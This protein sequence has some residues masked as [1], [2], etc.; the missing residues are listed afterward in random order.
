M[1]KHQLSHRAIFLLTAL[2]LALP[3]IALSPTVTP[4]YSQTT[5]TVSINPT[6]GP[7]GSPVVGTGSNWTAGDSMQ[8]SW[9]DTG[10]V[11][12]NT[13]TV[14]S[15]GRFSISFTIPVNATTG[16]HDIYFT[17]STSRY[18]LVATFTVAASQSPA[19]SWTSP[20]GNSGTFNV[21]SGSVTLQAS[22]SDNVGVARVKFTRWDAVAGKWVDLATV[23]SAPWQTTLAV[24]TLNS[25][26]NQVNVQA[27]DAAGNAST[28][29]YIWLNRTVAPFDAFLA[30]NNGKFLDFDGAYGAQC[31]DLVQYWSQAIGGPRFT[32]NYAKD[33]YKQTANFYTWIDKIGAAVPQKG[34]I[35]VWSGT[36]N[37]GP[38][39]VGIATGNG[40]KTF[41]EVFEQN[42]PTGS[43]SHL[44]TYSTYT[45]VLGWLRPPSTA[46]N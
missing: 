29:P 20:V 32:G 13:T 41:F 42:D 25:G 36:Y 3:I 44:K 24:S 19:V 40:T 46:V 11:L 38:G 5:S 16:P 6:Q 4:A 45:S 37:G 26:Y 27:W 10:A 21:S 7:A 9:R 34:D 8:A 33:L 17:D 22:A 39:H 12:G 31:V 2:L 30:K 28:S 1:H 18:F 14:D 15:A 43:N 35:V 23:S